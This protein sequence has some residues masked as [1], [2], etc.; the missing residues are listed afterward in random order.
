[1][2]DPAN[3]AKKT[4][5]I[6]LSHPIEVDGETVSS[7]TLRRPLVKD[8]IA[9]E[10]QP[11]AIGQE[12]ATISACAGLPFEAVGRLDAEDYRRVLLRAE[13]AFA[14]TPADQR[15]V[16]EE[17]GLGFMLA[18]ADGQAPSAGTGSREASGA[19]S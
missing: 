8:M 14:S 13:L 9:A 10:R 12:A 6:P 3:E 15:R 4:V 1:M 7:L 11:G 16:I 5:D 19:P 18:P 2:S 17:A